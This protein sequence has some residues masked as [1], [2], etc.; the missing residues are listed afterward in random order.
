MRIDPVRQE[1]IDAP[2]HLLIVGGPGCGKSTIALLKAQARLTAL[3]PEQRILFLSFSRAAVRQITDRMSG[4]LDRA[5]R[6]RLEV[7]TFHAFF[8]DVVRSHGRLLTGR[9]SSFITPDRERQIQADFDGDWKS[10]RQRLATEEGRYVFDLLADTTATLLERSAALRALYSSI[11]PLVIVDEFQDTNTDQWRAIKAI[12]GA[13]TIICLADPDQRIFDHLDGVEEQRLDDAVAH[14][15]PTPFDL[16]KDNHRS[17]GGG[18]LDYANAVLNNTFHAEPDTVRTW[19]YTPGYGVPWQTRVHKGVIAMQDYL[20]TQLGRTPTIA[21]LASVNSLL[22]QLSEVLATDTVTGDITLPAVDHALQWDPELTAAAGYVVASIMEWPGL[23]RV[24][25]VARTV[26]S[27]ADFYRAKLTG[28]TTGARDKIKAL[29]NGLVAFTSGKAI[30]SKTVK[31]VTAAYDAGISYTGRPVAD[32]QTARDRLLGSSELGEVLK[33]ARLLRLLNA[34]DALAW[35]LS[36]GWDGQSAY[37]DAAATVRAVLAAEALT[38]AQQPPEP[39]SL[40][41]MHRSKGKEFDGVVIVEGPYT[42][43][44]LDPG[45]DPERLRAQRRLLR[46]AITRARSAALFVRP[47]G[48]QR[49]TGMR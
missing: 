28:G 11:Y 35:G 40:M 26:E 42:G 20:S 30:R 24:E 18:L 10:E 31:A 13:S 45:W 9:P 37:R 29:D 27:L 1:I 33:H 39:V 47:Q 6:Q 34:T 15:A 23:P 5:S 16:S 22:G 21:V 4:V 14:L 43:T 44:L 36:D 12:S 3:E 41:S 8:L 48:S 2:G 38:A 46:V 19:T 32:W 49:L 25:A 7:R 17:A